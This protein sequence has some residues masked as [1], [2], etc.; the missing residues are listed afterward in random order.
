M[1]EVQDFNQDKIE[2]QIEQQQKKEIKLI[3]KQRKIPGLTLWEYNTKT[4]DLDKAK[5][6]KVDLHLK[7][8]SSA[9]AALESRHKVIVNEA[10]I[11]F[12]ALNEKNA[13]RKVK[14]AGL[15]LKF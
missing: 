9:E 8:L 1:K 6:S 14:K 10:C 4:F 15:K 2:V 11:Y 5:Y 7:S 13:E 12:Q 3:G